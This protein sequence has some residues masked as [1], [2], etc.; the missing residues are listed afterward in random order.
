MPVSHQEEVVRVITGF[1]DGLDA[2][3]DEG[4]EESQENTQ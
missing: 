3:G 2:Q 1:I 4:S